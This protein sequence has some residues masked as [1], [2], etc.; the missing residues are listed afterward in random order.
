MDK[1]WTYQ[2][3]LLKYNV[4]NRQFK[5]LL[6]PISDELEKIGYKNGQRLF[7]PKQ[8]KLIFDYLD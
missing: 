4:N 5:R 7:S 2:A 1:C 3:I 8:I 6:L